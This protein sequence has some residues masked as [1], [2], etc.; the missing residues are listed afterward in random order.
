MF[1][2]GMPVLIDGTQAGWITGMGTMAHEGQ[3]VWV[4]VD[5]RLRL[6]AGGDLYRLEP[7]TAT[8]PASQRERRQLV[9]EHR[10]SRPTPRHRGCRRVGRGP[11]PARP[12]PRGEHP[13]PS[14]HGSDAHQGVA[15]GWTDPAALDLP[16]SSSGPG[17]H[18]FK[19]A[20]RIRT[21]LGAR[22]MRERSREGQRD[23]SRRRP[24]RHGG[25]PARAGDPAWPGGMPAPAG[26]RAVWQLTSLISWRSQVQ[27]LP[28]PPKKWP[29]AWPLSMGPGPTKR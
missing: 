24:A 23:Q 19:V 5:G 10:R 17:H 1:T 8:R 22:R 14:H 21:P 27:I 3:V 4:D 29:H 20:T 16:L 7:A 25:T 15:D 13:P 6:F 28:P 18:P 11:A 2:L 26:C 9:G 12:A